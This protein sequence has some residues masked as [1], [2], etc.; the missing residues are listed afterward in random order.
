[1]KPEVNLISWKLKI[2]T[3]LTAHDNFDIRLF[4]SEKMGL[5]QKKTQIAQSSNEI[6]NLAEQ[7]LEYLSKKTAACKEVRVNRMKKKN[8]ESWI[9]VSWLYIF[10]K[11]T[12]AQIFFDFGF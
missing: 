4:L 7:G 11:H 6:K 10:N 12:V 2:S 5:S 3:F 8:N 1:M 9:R